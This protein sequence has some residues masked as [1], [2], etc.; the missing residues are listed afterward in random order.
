M[1]RIY[2]IPIWAAVFAWAGRLLGPECDADAQPSAFF[3]AAIG[4]FIGSTGWRGVGMLVG[5]LVGVNVGGQFDGDLG[6][7]LGIV[8]G[9]ICGWYL[10]ALL[11]RETNN[12]GPRENSTPRAARQSAHS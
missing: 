1:R 6:A 9:A 2:W 5:L 11:I 7:L 3:G 4:A 10:V 12:P 8:I